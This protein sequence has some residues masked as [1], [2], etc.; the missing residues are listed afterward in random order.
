MLN[1]RLYASTLGRGSV[2]FPSPKDE[3]KL[4][5]SFVGREQRLSELRVALEETSTYGHLFLISGEP[6]PTRHCQ[7]QS[8]RKSVVRFRS[9]VLSLAVLIGISRPAVLGIMLAYADEGSL[10]TIASK[11]FPNLTVAE[12]RLL[13]YA[14][15]SNQHR[16]EFSVG[17]T[18]PTPN[19]PSNDPAQSASWPAQRNIRAELIRWLLVDR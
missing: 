16:G 8:P 19:D 11:R 18:S 7:L 17:G 14:D 2:T 3:R 10:V 6:E 1:A 12:R 15:I 13:E 4:P 9:L 5:G